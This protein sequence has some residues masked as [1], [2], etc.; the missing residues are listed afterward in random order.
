MKPNSGKPAAPDTSDSGY[1]RRVAFGFLLMAMLVF[2]F[3]GWAAW[4]SLSAAV[5]APGQVVVESS[6]KKVQHPTGGVVGVINV[7]NGDRVT[8]GDIVMRLDDTQTRANFG[9]IVAQLT[10]LTGRKAR[11]TAERDDEVRIEFP[12][13]F[14]AG[15]KEAQRVAE[16]ERRLFTTKHKTAE[17]QK[18]QLRERVGQFR[19]EIEGLNKQAKAKAKELSLVEDELS[20][21]ERMYNQKLVPVTRLLAMQREVTRIEGEHGSLI[22]Q[23]ARSGGQIAETELK[24]LEIDETVRSDAQK[25]IREIEGRIAEL[26]EQRVAADDILKRVDLRAPQTGVVHE[27]TVHTVGGVIAPG[28][29]V[30]SIVPMDDEKSIEVHLAPTDIDQVA[31]GQK[32]LLRFP[33][34]NQRT[35]PELVG[36]VSRLAVDVTKDPQSGAS[37]YVARIKVN[38]ND[39]GAFKKMQLVAGMPVESFIQ[40]GERSAL[41]YFV[42]PL[43]DQFARTFREQ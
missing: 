30:M 26:S 37:F 43:R 11:L 28:D 24:M 23:I 9:I 12:E 4:F 2:G 1:G 7:K 17:D 29:T 38:D 33:A 18:A 31:L 34:F 40:T 25:E 15:G 6:L 36:A 27:L 10:E 41:S 8:A 35:T 16:G 5:I 3:G 13:G 14:E 32:A 20:R 21:L 39:V 22:S 42:K 19:Y